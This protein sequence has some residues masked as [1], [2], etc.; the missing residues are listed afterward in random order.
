MTD[1]PVTST[2]PPTTPAPP[3]GMDVHPPEATTPGHPESS[4]RGM[5]AWI[6]LAAVLALLIG[7]TIGYAASMPAKNDVTKQRDAATAQVTQLQN[8]LDKSNAAGSSAS[9]ARDKCSKAA[10]D[11][12]DLIDQDQ[13]LWNDFATLMNMTPGSPEEIA[14]E[15]HM[16]TQADTMDAQSRVVTDE[17]AT[18]RAAVN[19]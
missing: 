11:A 12:K 7:A 17:L 3:G 2:P 1:T 15:Q 5:G 16:N 18:C 9:S 10:V 6:A 14:Q 8:D 13:N 19:G 4:R